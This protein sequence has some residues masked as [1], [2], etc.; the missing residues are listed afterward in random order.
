MVTPFFTCY[1]LLVLIN[2]V[3]KR[4]GSTVKTFIGK[5]VNLPENKGKYILMWYYLSYLITG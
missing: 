3:H 4:C 5:F 1:A 2:H